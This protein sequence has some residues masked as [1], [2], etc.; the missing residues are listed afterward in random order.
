MRRCGRVWLL[1]VPFAVL[2]SA[3]G[4]ELVL[5]AYTLV[6]RRDWE[7]IKAEPNHLFRAS[8][9]P[10][11][12]YEHKTNYALGGA[13]QRVVLNEHGIRDSGTVSPAGRWKVVMAGDSLAFGQN[14]DQKE[15]FTELM[16]EDFD[17][18][19]GRVKVLNFG[20]GGYDVADV[21]EFVRVKDMVYQADAFVYVM[22]LTD[23]ARKNTVYE[24]ADNGL[25][26][27]YRL[28]WLKTPMFVR[29][30]IYRWKKQ[31]RLSSPGWY[32]WLVDGNGNQAWWMQKVRLMR[33]NANEHGK[34]FAVVI[35]PAGCAYENGRYVLQDLH[36]R[37]ATGLK[38][39]GINVV[40]L[41]PTFLAR[42]A[43]WLDGT[44]HLTPD[45]HRVLAQTLSPLVV[46]WH[47]TASQPTEK[48]P[49]QSLGPSAA[50]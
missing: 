2:V 31:G 11:L 22:S 21:A 27:M 10:V 18:Q 45:G 28:P 29:K 26:R 6:L 37:L 41:A 17:R 32:R 20:V 35:M 42:P 8:D 13:R 33:D 34:P 5:Q 25:F 47:H 16:Q 48:A 9:N 36:D 40:D 15:I 46:K 23:F 43:E 44:D 1:A 7:K 4:F 19:G 49:V 3:V 30:A 24:G 14:V 50:R 12:A 38:Q 39:E